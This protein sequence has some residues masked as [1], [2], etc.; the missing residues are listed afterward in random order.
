MFRKLFT[1]SFLPVRLPFFQ[2]QH[3]VL[4][5]F[6]SQREVYLTRLKLAEFWI[7]FVPWTGLV[8]PL[9]YGVQVDF[10]SLKSKL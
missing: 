3:E 5:W 10:G 7:W 1:N 2:K 4:I 6:H 8:L 9:K